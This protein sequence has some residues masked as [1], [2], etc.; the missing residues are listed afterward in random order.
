MRL[1]LYGVARIVR[2]AHFADA[3]AEGGLV[4]REDKFGLL[5]I[6]V[7]GTVASLDDGWRP[8]WIACGVL[9]AVWTAA[10]LWSRS[11]TR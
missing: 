7:C 11:R 8:F 6:I 5:G 1:S 3:R 4:A 9:L 10:S 2:Y